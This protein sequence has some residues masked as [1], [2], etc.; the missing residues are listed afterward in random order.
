MSPYALVYRKACHLPLELEHKVQWALK[1]LNLDLPSTGEARKLQLNELA[2]WRTTAY[3]N[4]KLYK[5]QT[6][7]WHDSRICKKDL[8]IGQRVLLFNSHL[9]LFLS[10]LK[11]WW[12]G[13]FIVK[14]VFPHGAVELSSEDGGNMFKVNGQRVKPYYGGMVN[15]VKET[16]DLAGQA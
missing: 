11:S 3:E 13:P 4:T 1:K 12:S 15:R 2:E 14:G 7:R 5:K 9:H 10:K 16:I 6:K 8:A